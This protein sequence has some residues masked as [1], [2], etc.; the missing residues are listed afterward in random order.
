[1]PATV[2]AAIAIIRPEC[3]TQLI[4]VQLPVLSIF[5][6]LSLTMPSPRLGK[7]PPSELPQPL[8]QTSVFVGCFCILL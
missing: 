3:F 7:R 6:K 2:F 1:M 5:P 8:L 4:S